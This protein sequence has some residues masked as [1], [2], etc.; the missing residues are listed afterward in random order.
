MKKDF[1]VWKIQDN[2]LLVFN[3]NKKIL[4]LIN[5]LE[6]LLL[7][8]KGI[9]EIKIRQ[10]LFNV[11]IKME[12]TVWDLTNKISPFVCKILKE[13]YVKNAFKIIV[14]FL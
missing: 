14:L 8:E 6:I 5:A 13:L 1:L 11:L 3:A 7:L 4:K 10:S 2:K 12:D 9:E